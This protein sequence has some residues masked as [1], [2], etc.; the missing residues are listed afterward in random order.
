VMFFVCLDCKRNN[1]FIANIQLMSVQLNEENKFELTLLELFCT[2]M[3]KIEDLENDKGPYIKI[4]ERETLRTSDRYIFYCYVGLDLFNGLSTRSVENTFVENKPIDDGRLKFF[5]D[6][7]NKKFKSLSPEQ[8]ETYKAIYY[9]FNE[10]ERCISIREKWPLPK[11]MKTESK[12]S[13]STASKKRKTSISRR[14]DAAYQFIGS[15]YYNI[16]QLNFIECWNQMT[17]YCKSYF[18]NTLSNFSDTYRQD[19]RF[20]REYLAKEGIGDYYIGNGRALTEDVFCFQVTF[21]QKVLLR[22]SGLEK[23]KY[24]NFTI[25]NYN[26]LRKIAKT[27]KAKIDNAGGKDLNALPMYFLFQDDSLTKIV[28]AC[29]GYGLTSPE[30]FFSFD[31]LVEDILPRTQFCICKWIEGKWFIDSIQNIQDSDQLQQY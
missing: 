4:L 9:C 29:F 28:N 6:K 25:G 26:E 3:A 13:I 19:I 24:S 14:A 20:G 10:W 7:V 8:K 18:D 23:F 1:K 21:I 16:H 15:F 11:W 30:F 12:D 22:S 27:L 2:W 5:F 31:K 17:I